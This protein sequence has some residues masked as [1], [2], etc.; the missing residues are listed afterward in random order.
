MTTAILCSM[1]TL[2]K[3]FYVSVIGLVVAALVI[4]LSV[5]IVWRNQDAGT[6]PLD[7]EGAAPV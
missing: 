3:G 7:T 6:T 2:Q 5:Y 1:N 4:L